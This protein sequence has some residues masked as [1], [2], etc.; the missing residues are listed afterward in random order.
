MNIDRNSKALGKSQEFAHLRSSITDIQIDSTLEKLCN[1]YQK[2][3]YRQ[4]A[5]ATSQNALIGFSQYLRA[6]KN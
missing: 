4:P 5:V 3:S 2:Q 1:G 6:A